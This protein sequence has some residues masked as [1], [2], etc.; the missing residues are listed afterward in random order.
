LSVFG[1]ERLVHFATCASTTGLVSAA[2]V[3]TGPA[4]ARRTRLVARCGVIRL[5]GIGAALGWRRIDG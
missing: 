2:S 5:N 4:G 1:S 3:E